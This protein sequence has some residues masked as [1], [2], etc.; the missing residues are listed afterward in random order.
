MSSSESDIV[1]LLQDIRRWLKFANISEARSKV[2]EAISSENE[3]TQRDN[4][5]IY[6]LSDGEHSTS[7]IEK[8]VSVTDTT[9]SKRQSNWADMGLMEKSAENSPYQKLIELEDVGLSAPDLP[10]DE[11][12]GE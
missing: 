8:F 5:I 4:L 10:D 11:G 9:V 12:N 1:D 2:H 7:D 6:Y 3:E